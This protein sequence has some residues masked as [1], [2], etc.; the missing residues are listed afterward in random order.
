MPSYNN[1]N[2]TQPNPYSIKQQGYP[3][4]PSWTSS[5]GI[6]SW[7]NSLSANLNDIG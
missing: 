2:Y 4:H 6:T 3:I 5:S 7:N 1:G